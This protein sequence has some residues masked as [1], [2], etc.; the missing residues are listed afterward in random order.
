MQMQKQGQKLRNKTKNKMLASHIKVAKGFFTRSRG[1][2]GTSCLPAEQG[3]WLWSCNSIHTFFM[4]YPIDCI[5]VDR[6]LKVKA[7]FL[8]V[9]PWRV[10][11]PVWGAK[12]VFE[13]ETGSLSV[14]EHIE[15]GDLLY[16]GS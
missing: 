6:N 2:I 10:I 3:L 1:L 13:L 8:K 15:V 16:V 14:P 5:F 9:V 4:K 11:L 7:V 12:S